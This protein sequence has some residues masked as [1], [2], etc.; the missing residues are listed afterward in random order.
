M[1]LVGLIVLMLIHLIGLC[2][3]ISV[4][5]RNSRI[6]P[7]V[8]VRPGDATKCIDDFRDG[9]INL[10]VAT[11]VI[12]EVSDRWWHGI[13]SFVLCVLYHAKFAFRALM[14]Q[15]QMLSSAMTISK[16]RLSYRNVLGGQDKRQVHSLSWLNVKSKFIMHTPSS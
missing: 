12:E 2:S 9:R 5:A 7:S 13:T 4:A 8:K 15:R 1:I 16:I 6:T 10:I 14:F 11:S 3:S